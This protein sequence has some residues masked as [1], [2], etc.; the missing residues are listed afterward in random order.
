M[1]TVTQTEKLLAVAHGIIGLIAI[2]FVATTTW[3]D[4]MYLIVNSITTLAMFAAMHRLSNVRIRELAPYAN[5]MLPLLILGLAV[6]MLTFFLQSVFLGRKQLTAHLSYRALL[7]VAFELTIS[8]A[9]T[10]LL[11]PINGGL[12]FGTVNLLT[13]FTYSGTLQS[14]F[15]FLESS[16]GNAN[17]KAYMLVLAIAITSA[18]L[19]IKSQG[20]STAVSTVKMGV[21]LFSTLVIVLGNVCGLT[22]PTDDSDDAF[23][24]FSTSGGVLLTFVALS[25][26]AS[27]LFANRAST[28]YFDQQ[29]RSR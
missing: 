23:R 4:G 16:A 19:T 12:S 9:F 14:D 22:T 5:E 2:I 18:L 13:L 29:M 3:Y 11:P 26:I 15:V 25:I 27:L 21:F 20:E 28:R 24:D 1:A 17:D 8:Y 6:P 10:K 7:L